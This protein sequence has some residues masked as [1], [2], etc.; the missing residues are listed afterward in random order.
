MLFQG[1]NIRFRTPFLQDTSTW[2]GDFNAFHSFDGVLDEFRLWSVARTGD[3]IVAGMHI[4]GFPDGTQQAG[5]EALF[6]FND[7]PDSHMAIDATEHQNAMFL[8]RLWD[9]TTS[10]N[11]VT[12]PGARVP[13][14]SP[15]YVASRAPAY[16]GDILVMAAPGGR[17]IIELMAWAPDNAP[18]STTILSAP[19]NGTLHVLTGSLFEASSEHGVGAEVLA[20]ESIIDPDWSR[21]QVHPNAL[22]SAADLLSIPYTLC[23][24][25]HHVV[26]LPRI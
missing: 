25:L 15:K 19:T 3:E 9:N 13:L 14:T 1:T 4:H 21:S 10:V 20:G 8:G 23:M 24:K 6:H 2:L 5:L 22:I 16:G 17:T 7:G 11:Y 12:S 26:P 18:L